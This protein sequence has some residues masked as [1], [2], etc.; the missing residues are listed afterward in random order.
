ME[1]KLKSII[2]R[3]EEIT[4]ALNSPDVANDMNRYREVSREFKRLTPIA[5]TAKKYL[6]ICGELSSNKE[7]INSSST[8][9]DLKELAYEE[10]QRL[11]EEKGQLEEELKFLLIPKTLMT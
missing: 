1:E 5:E 2:Q 9:K 3:Y 8:E 4:R 10:N 6:K 11:E 7:L